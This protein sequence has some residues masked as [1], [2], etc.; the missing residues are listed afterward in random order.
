MQDC[1]LAAIPYLQGCWPKS[2]L[3]VNE[4]PQSTASSKFNS[5]SPIHSAEGSYGDLEA[6]DVTPEES[7]GSE[8]VFQIILSGGQGFCTVLDGN[9]DPFDALSTTSSPRILMLLQFSEF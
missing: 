3:L 8:N 7:P 9:P 5:D 1:H 2:K 4:R 6:E